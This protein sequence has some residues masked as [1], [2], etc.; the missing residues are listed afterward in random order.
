MSDAVCEPSPLR[1]R[2]DTESTERY[3]FRVGENVQFVVEADLC[4][5]CGSCYS[6]CPHEAIQI[7]YRAQVGIYL[8]EIDLDACQ[9]CTLCV[10]ICPGFELDLTDRSGL[11]HPRH[12]DPLVGPYEGIY[13]AASNRKDIHSRGTSGGM[14]TQILVQLFET[15]RID[16]A[17]VTRQHPDDPLKAESY[18]ACSPG[19]L[20]VS[21]KSKYCP[22]PLNVA[23]RRWI[24]PGT[25]LSASLPKRVAY[26]GL[27]GH[28][29]GLRLLQRM[30]PKLMQTFPHVLSLFTAHVP[31]QR[32]TEFVLYKQG[33]GTNDVAELEYRGGGIPGR[34][35]ILTRSGAEHFVPHLHWT[36]SGHAFPLF[37]YPV[38]EWLYFDKISEWADFSIGDNWQEWTRD[39]A[40][41]STVVTRSL[42][43]DKIFHEIVVRGDATF[44]TMS[45]EDLVKD[46]G[47][48][49]KLDIGNRLRVWRTLG[50]PVPMYTRTFN[51][52]NRRMLDTVRFAFYVFLCKYRIPFSIMNV[53]IWGDYHLRALPAK[54]LKKLAA[55]FTRTVRG[56]ASGFSSFMPAK[57]EY[58]SKRTRYKVVLIGGYGYKDIGDEAMPHAI[59]LHFRKRFGDDLELVMLSWDPDYTHAFHGEQ[60]FKDID[61]ISPSA[62]ASLRKRIQA[63]GGA[64]VF[65]IGALAQR[66]NVRLR[67][68]PSARG[69]LDHLYT[70]DILFNVGGGNLT[71]VIPKE[72]YRKTT[73]YLAS[74]ILGKPIFISGQTMGPYYPGLA[75]EYV[76]FCLDRVH[77]IS[78]RDKET[79][80]DRLRQIGVLRPTMFDAA[81]DA[82]SLPQISPAE[83][84]ALIEEDIGVSI[85]T[86]SSKP[87][88]FLNLKG[89]LRMFK[90]RGR[91]SEVSNETAKLSAL[92]DRLIEHYDATV[93]FV[94]T[95]FLHGVD[96]RCLHREARSLMRHSGRAYVLENEYTDLQL[97]GFLAL[98]DAALGARYHFNVFAAANCTPFFGFASGE[99]QRTKLR[100]LAALCELPRCYFDDDLEFADADAL[101]T[102]AAQVID[103]SVAI[104]AH[105]A[106]VA[107][108]LA[109]AS[110][111]VVDIAGDYLEGLS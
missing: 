12:I 43:A 57:Q 39:Q 69:T 32:A 50:R 61:G 47:L 108:R 24:Y 94:A 26:V 16:A 31:S 100:G 6:V 106:V 17:L 35:R 52:P 85:G 62:S 34:M 97:K 88:F 64:V 51:H 71:S 20:A 59:R 58:P 79:S 22:V 13:R 83:A 60:S 41:A 49:T 30:F 101:I 67:L 92:A 9:R 7:V 81:D 82:M 55:R 109:A 68:W 63:V 77:T 5:G 23:L 1:R 65:L 111:S 2:F 15:G 40:G 28:V 102:R 36:Y 21:Q 48:K 96:D 99:Y 105:L 46:Q 29:H 18:L 38:R 3:G 93:I 45:A 72:L 87:L 66:W 110:H 73:T 25:A 103:Q 98:P 8:P 80:R 78:F 53:I 91:S 19:E 70:T 95:D 76:R 107:P 10:Q 89:S 27:P 42:D 86:F 54:F 37:F 4:H 44:T 11:A 104:R 74:A 90:G 56:I 84:R 14:I 75:L 33:I